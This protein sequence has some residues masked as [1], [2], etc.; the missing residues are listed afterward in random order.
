MSC[1]MFFSAISE[2]TIK[3]VCVSLKKLL[4][5]IMEL[6]ELGILLAPIMWAYECGKDVANSESCSAKKLKNGKSFYG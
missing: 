3:N 6:W 4:R 2:D 1:E 5:K